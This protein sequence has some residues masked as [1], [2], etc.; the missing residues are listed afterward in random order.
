MN[1]LYFTMSSGQESQDGQKTNKS[2]FWQQLLIIYA[3]LRKV[4]AS[5]GKCEKCAGGARS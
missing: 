4:R 5:N 1:P 2:P 3:T